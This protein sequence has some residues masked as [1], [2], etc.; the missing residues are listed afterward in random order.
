MSDSED[1][2]R[3]GLSDTSDEAGAIRDA[4]DDE[5]DDDDDD[6]DAE[7][8]AE[9]NAGDDD[10]A[11]S[12]NGTACAPDDAQERQILQARRMAPA[13]AA[14]P[15]AASPP[16]ASGCEH[17]ERLY[18]TCVVCGAEV[19]ETGAGDELIALRDTDNA[20]PVIHVTAPRAKRLRLAN[21]QTALQER[22]LM[23]VLDLDHTLLNSQED[24][25]HLESDLRRA[26]NKEL[27]RC[28]AQ[29]IPMH[30]R[31]L[32]FFPH[33]VPGGQ[34]MF[35]KLRPGVREF[36]KEAF[37]QYDLSINTLGMSAYAA[38]MA[39]LLDFSGKMFRSILSRE[40]ADVEGDAGREPT[41]TKALRLN[42]H[43]DEATTLILDDSVRVWP[44]FQANVLQVPQYHFFPASS[45]AL[46]QCGTTSL[47]AQGTDEESWGG[48]AAGEQARAGGDEDDE[49]EWERDDAA[50]GDA[51]GARARREKKRGGG[52][53][54]RS[55]LCR[56]GAHKVPSVLRPTLELL[57]ALHK[58]YFEA[59]EERPGEAP[60][61]RQLLRDKRKG[62]LAGHKVCFSRLWETGSD[63][64]R[65]GPWMLARDL[66]AQCT[67]EMSEDV[68][69]LVAGADNTDK[70]KTAMRRAVSVVS[71]DWLFAS[72]LQL[73]PADPFRYPPP[74]LAE[75][76][77]QR[78]Y[79]GGAA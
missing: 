34:G 7:L 37:K 26:L 20:G 41:Y 61:L 9:L 62:T 77:P 29:G 15:S 43:A 64:T 2:S 66:G 65:Q 51:E 31:E 76:Q 25:E 44:G 50:P 21:V 57:S 32:F 48:G 70:V 4:T 30:E 16:A 46:G 36:L 75:I 12:A 11:M 19:P 78:R 40:D 47:L 23:L 38:R 56:E 60:D 3:A 14:A 59:L 55:A 79:L 6:L 39:S 22:R 33:P 73:S 35:T 74:K 69:V 45:K 68:T 27:H 71:V 10:D 13:D 52:P 17:P 18:G 8:E 28:D 5:V 67:V 58:A 54:G 72:G 42:L 24:G 53:A 1:D 49:D 63:S